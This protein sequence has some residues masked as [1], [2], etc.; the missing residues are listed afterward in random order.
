[1]PSPTGW[2][3]CVWPAYTRLLR[4]VGPWYDRLILFLVAS[5]RR[6]ATACAIAGSLGG[7]ALIAVVGLI[8]SALAHRWDGYWYWWEPA[9]FG[10][11][12]LVG[13]ALTWRR[14]RWAG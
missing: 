1:M 10:L 8:R 7:S 5:D 14:D 2:R 6:I 9:L 13:W 12:G 11:A 4:R 3:S